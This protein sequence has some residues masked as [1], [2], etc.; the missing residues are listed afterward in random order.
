MNW[1][2][3]RILF[4]LAIIHDLDTK[5]IAFVLTFPQAPL[6]IDAFIELPY[7]F[8]VKTWNQ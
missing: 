6:D 2:S 1:L 3:V 8:A 4:A 7:G 5:S